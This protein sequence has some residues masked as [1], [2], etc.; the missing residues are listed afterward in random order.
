MFLVHKKG[1]RQARNQEM[2]RARIQ[3]AG[4]DPWLHKAYALAAAW[5]LNSRTRWEKVTLNPIQCMHFPSR[6]VC[7]YIY[8]HTLLDSSVKLTSLVIANIS[9]EI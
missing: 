1:L 4:L 8:I 6:C 7:I 3:E 9:K 2:A 5:L